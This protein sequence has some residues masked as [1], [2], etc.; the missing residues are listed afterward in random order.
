MKNPFDYFRMIRILESRNA[1]TDTENFPKFGKLLNFETLPFKKEGS[2]I[3][4]RNCGGTKCPSGKLKEL[5]FKV[6]YVA[7]QWHI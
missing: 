7:K 4:G 1:A 2:E 6:I 3:S 5:K